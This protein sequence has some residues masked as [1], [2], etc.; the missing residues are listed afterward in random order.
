[1]YGLPHSR[2]DLIVWGRAEEQRVEPELC[3]R[4]VM[5]NQL[6]KWRASW[7][8]LSSPEVAATIAVAVTWTPPGGKA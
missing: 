1:V 3:S 4:R 7:K 5:P 8:C 6:A 2:K